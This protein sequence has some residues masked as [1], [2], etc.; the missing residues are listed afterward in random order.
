MT[1]RLML[2][3]GGKMSE[4]KNTLS[5]IANELAGYRRFDLLKILQTA[6]SRGILFDLED[7]L[8]LMAEADP[9]Y[10]KPCYLPTFIPSFISAYAKN[11]TPKSA[12]DVWAGIGATI[13]PIVHEIELEKAI[14]LERNREAYE[15]ARLLGHETG[16]EWRLG[17]PLSMLD[18]VKQDFD[19]ILG[20]LPWNMNSPQ[21]MKFQLENKEIEIRDHENKLLILKAS[22]LLS[23][24]G[25]GF[26][27]VDPGFPIKRY[28]HTVYSNLSHFGLFID[29]ILS[30][31]SGT[32]PFTSLGGLLVI[33]RKQKT[34][35]LFVGELSSNEKSNDVVLHNLKARKNGKIP[36]HGILINLEEFH[37]FQ[38]LILEYETNELGRQLGL[39]PTPLK[40]LILEINLT[41][42]SDPNAFVDYPN[43]VYLPLIGKS[44]AVSSLADLR[45]KPH[46]YAQ[47]VLKP[48]GAIAE[49]LA[50]FFNTRI[51]LKI[52]ESLQSVTIIPKITKGQLNK[53]T[54][55]V[56][57][58]DIQTEAL[59]ANASIVELS[60]QLE[61]LKKQLW[62]HPR[63]AKEI[64][65]SV[66]SLNQERSFE[67][68]LDSL[69][70]PLASILWLY[71]T[72]N[73][74]KDKLDHLLNFFE[75][76][77]LYN[78]VLML[79][80]Y[81]SDLGFYIRH[82]S[83]WLDTDPQHMDWYWHAGFGNWNII[84]ERLAKSTRRFLSDEQTRNH[85]LDLFGQPTSRYVKLLTDKKLFAILKIVGNYRNLPK[86]TTIQSETNTFYYHTD[87]LGSTRMVTDESKNIIT[88]ATYEPF[89]ESTVTGEES[90]LYT[91]KEK[92]ST[93]L[94]YYGARYYDPGLG[95]FIT[96]DPIVGK[97]AI[98]QSLNR[99]TYCLNNPVKMI[100]PTGMFYK[101]C[102]VE[103]GCTW[104]YETRSSKNPDRPD[105]TAYDK[106]GNEIV[107]NQEWEELIASKDPEDQARA[108]FI[109]LLL[110]HPDI[111]YDGDPMTD[112]LTELPDFGGSFNTRN[113]LF[114][115]TYKGEE[116][117]LI[118]SIS[119]H[120]A[121]PNGELGLTGT[122]TIEIEGE[123]MKDA[124][125][126][127]LFQGAFE[128]YAHLY[129]IVGH[130]GV[131][132]KQRLNSKGYILRDPITPE[133]AAYLWNYHH[134]MIVPYPWDFNNLLWVV[135]NYLVKPD[136]NLP[137]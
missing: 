104:I 34:K 13:A 47:I 131:H 51:G 39:S 68:W 105:W 17:S 49:Y 24:R 84:G 122:M 22:V 117:L 107:N 63:K 93:D 134:S 80:A 124:I 135:Q 76:L 79:S 46:N 111:E 55:Y 28:K 50:H 133:I 127:I 123:G 69:P 102:L 72:E 103:G 53:A 48:N 43:A 58:N 36:Q 60:M 128:S 99:Y 110:T 41:K 83:A 101:M 33:I 26:F 125:R 137:S 8:Q 25:V 89:G 10:S 75:A 74:S 77:S 100:D 86:R 38:T 15:I 78:A 96:R 119:P 65:K 4:T 71:H 113:F 87:H 42:S 90:Y 118:I 31:P 3:R 29:A 106:N 88:D 9:R 35:Q 115:I 92:D 94:Y 98:P 54:V 108:A 64:L 132:I 7:I 114:R 109:M 126:M 121:G 81:A 52:R 91:G 70:F 5:D 45:I 67:N 18:E 136:R 130:E 14:A 56:P 97:K 112:S 129:H 37:S 16:I 32:F 11:L 73:D 19:I 23:R 30:L 85:C 12:L 82:S 116:H 120:Q 21:S 2:S 95:R 27:I 6:K 62:E 66:N 44:P 20:T 61:T 59:Q 40:N 57:D 1:N